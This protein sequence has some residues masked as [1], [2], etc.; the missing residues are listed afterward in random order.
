VDDPPRRIIGID[1]QPIL[2]WI[3]GAVSLLAGLLAISHP[4][5]LRST[6]GLV[7]LMTANAIIYFMLS[8]TL[9]AL[10]LL[11]VNL[12]AALVV[13]FVLVRPRRMKLGSPGRLRLNI[14]KFIAFF[15][16]IWIC[17]MIWWALTQVPSR[18]LESQDACL[19]AAEGNQLSSEL[20]AW[21][22]VF[23]LSISVVTALVVVMVR[24]QKD[25]EDSPG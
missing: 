14:T 24:R 6:Q 12:G 2:F 19:P 22:A 21:T 25:P 13:W 4:R 10:E 3:V 18:I 8:A 23:L 17:A 15:M 9:L 20:A 16:A 11:V 5:P 7:A 1:M